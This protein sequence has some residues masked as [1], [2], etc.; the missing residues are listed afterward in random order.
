[1]PDG[2]PDDV[3][4]FREHWN[5]L[6]DE[7]LLNLAVQS[8]E[9]VTDPDFLL[10]NFSLTAE[11]C[12]RELGMIP[13]PVQIEAAFYLYHGQVTEMATGEGKTIAGILPAA[14]RAQGPGS[15]H[16]ATSN[17]YLA[18]RDYGQ[19]SP[20]LERLGITSGFLE[21]QAPH[22]LK[23]Q[24]YA[25]EVIY[26]PGY[27]FGFDYLRDQIE[28]LRLDGR[29]LGTGFRM[30]MRGMGERHMPKI[31]QGRCVY[32]IIDE[33]DSVLIDE[34]SSPLLITQTAK[35]PSKT[36]QI[37]VAAAAA[38]RALI[39]ARD[40][41]VTANIQ[42]IEFT[43][44]GRAHC[45]QFL[46][47]DVKRLLFRPWH[48][49]VMKA[50]RVEI[51]MQRDVHYVVED[52][53]IIIVDE[54]TGRRFEE[55]TW[56]DGLHQAVEAGEGVTITQEN[57]T[58]GSITRQR[59]YGFYESVSGMTGTASESK[60]EL[61]ENYGKGVRRIPLH[62]PSIQEVWPERI[63]KT[64][65]QKLLAVVASIEVLH[66]MK[67]PV[68]VGTR[69]IRQ[70]EEIARTLDRSG[71]SYHLLNAKQD[72]DEAS[73][74]ERAGQEAQVT[75]ATNMAGRGTHISL[76]EEVETNG[77]LHVICYERNES[78]R[79]DRQ[80]QGRSARQGQPGSFQ[81]FNAS[82]DFLFERFAPELIELMD[83]AKADE[84]GELDEAW[85]VKLHQ[86]QKTVEVQQY[87]MR[88]DLMLHDRWLEDIRRKI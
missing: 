69:T 61:S 65:E 63:F 5:T 10:K 57:S 6:S 38:A 66:R 78:S 70:S 13:Y 33:I 73:I 58:A 80:L 35:G 24:T 14:A 49:Y 39:E 68:L 21:A 75:I 18:E 83:A 29:K 42:K 2:F 48:D 52:D 36:P 85:L 32:A 3:L 28:V 81:A 50:L 62:R 47:N 19:L 27:E 87:K 26:G 46:D 84:R 1:M 4:A 16:V 11:A 45:Y 12:R 9:R 55:R 22:E 76:A 60:R 23:K 77:G 74:I 25:N 54:F 86:L 8:R 41:K 15:V 82:T 17:A 30:K 34:A 71:I 20:V 56:R 79:I 64:E 37:Y 44:D 51:F 40:Y 59:F 7:E 67:R 53:Q 72:K 31:A 88:R 43:N